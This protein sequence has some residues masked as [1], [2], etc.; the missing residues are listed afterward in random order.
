MVFSSTTPNPSPIFLHRLSQAK[1]VWCID[2][3]RDSF[4]PKVSWGDLSSFRRF[5]TNISCF[6]GPPPRL[7]SIL[8]AL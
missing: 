7:R 2:A 5:S 6:V 8:V 4:H 3:K 1:E